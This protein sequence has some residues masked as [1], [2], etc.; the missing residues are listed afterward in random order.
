LG[1]GKTND[2]TPTLSGTGTPGD[3]ITVKDANGTTIA[4]AG[5]DY[6]L[7]IATGQLSFSGVSTVTAQRDLSVSVGVGDVTQ[8]NTTS[9][10]AGRDVLL[11][12]GS[13]N[14][15]SHERTLV[16]ATRDVAVRIQVGDIGINDDSRWLSGQDQHWQ[17][18]QAGTFVMEDAQ[19]E[20]QS[21]RDI[22]LSVA[23]DVRVD[24]MQAAETLRIQAVRGAILDNTAAETDLMAAR[25]LALDAAKGI[26]LPWADNLNTWITGTLTANNRESGGINVQNW[27]GLTIGASGVLNRGDGNL[28]L[29]SGGTM[30]HGEVRNQNEEGLPNSVIN[31]RGQKLFLI[32]NQSERYLLEQWG[33]RTISFVN[34]RTAVP[35]S[36][37]EPLQDLPANGK[38]E[39]IAT[40]I[41]TQVSNPEDAATRLLEWASSVTKTQTMSQ[42]IRL[43]DVLRDGGDGSRNPFGSDLLSDIRSMNDELQ[44][45]RSLQ[46]GRALPW[47]SLDSQ[48]TV[49]PIAPQSD[50]GLDADVPQA[51][52]TWPSS[53]DLPPSWHDRPVLRQAMLLADDSLDQPLI[54]D[55]APEAAL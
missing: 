16:M 36:A 43:A 14:L 26:G 18:S 20:L 5:Q 19:T 28:I 15:L 31:P 29:I 44:G 12:M 39:T 24:W 42:P 54:E 3:T 40:L 25:H 55:E 7:S 47:I 2:T 33:N 49:V 37:K 9:W 48:E 45:A 46:A 11:D 23:D 32:H 13:G 52:G 10:T 34:V 50:S 38:S 22:S 53:A 17:I 4:T 51:F 30:N 41:P 6:A 1:D 21:G 8:H 27:V 35:E